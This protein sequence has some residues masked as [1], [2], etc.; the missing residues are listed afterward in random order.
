MVPAMRRF[1][2]AIVPGQRYRERPGAYAVIRDGKDVLVTE[3]ASPYPE[4]QLPG[5]GIDPGEGPL[6]ALQRECYEETGWKIQPLRRL[7]AFQRYAWMPEYDRWAHKVCH[8]WLARPVR[9]IGPP[10]E[11][12]HTAVWMP[13]ATALVALAGDG[14]RHF[15]AAAVG[16]DRS[17]G[18]H[19]ILRSSG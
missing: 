16:A 12:G 9:R 7:G 6:L 3:Q 13:V 11:P 14:D 15:L 2:E 19:A 1:G 18:P 10:T 5:G 4:F 17:G 8:V